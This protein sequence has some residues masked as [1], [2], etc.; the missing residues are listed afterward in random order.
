MAYLPTLI[1]LA[2][3]A[4][5][6]ASTVRLYTKPGAR[7]DL[8]FLTLVFPL[9]TMAVLLVALTWPEVAG[10]QLQALYLTWSPYH[11]AAQSFGLAVMY[12]YRSGCRLTDGEKSPLW[13][14]S[15]LPFA[16]AFLGGTSSGLGWF[17]P[18]ATIMSIPDLAMFLAYLTRGVTFLIFVLP[19]VLLLGRPLRKQTPMPLIVLSLLLANGVWWTVLDYVDAFVWAT[20]FHGLQYL[21]IAVIF[22]VKDRR[23]EPTNRHGAVY[24][25]LWFYGVSLALAYALFSCWP[26]AF[27]LAGFG[28]AESMLLVTAVINVHHFRRLTRVARV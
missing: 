17:V 9:V 6:A 24:H 19:V 8:R 18:R 25:S 10:A 1:L 22:H 23:A 3:S 15:M 4:H 5:F 11:Y 14:V 12:C 26:Y 16:R 20:I 7:D 13:W 21:A 27:V 28:L 2:N